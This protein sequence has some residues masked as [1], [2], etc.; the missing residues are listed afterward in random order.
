RLARR[1]LPPSALRMLLIL[2]VTVLACRGSLGTFP[3]NKDDP[4]ISSLRLLNDI[5]PNGISAFFW[6]LS[7]RDNDKRF[8]NVTDEEGARLYL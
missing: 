3:L 4:G 2:G 7:E 8:T 1:P 6:A 5:A